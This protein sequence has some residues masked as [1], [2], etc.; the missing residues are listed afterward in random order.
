MPDWRQLPNKPASGTWSVTDPI[1]YERY[2]LTTM[3]LV[4]GR[5]LVSGGYS[6]ESYNLAECELYDG[7][8]DHWTKTGR[9]RFARL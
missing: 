6:C 4:E 9:M 2:W 3:T 8:T 7:A 1:E 5:V